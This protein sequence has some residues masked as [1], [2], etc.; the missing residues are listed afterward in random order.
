MSGNEMKDKIKSL[1][2]LRAIAVFLVIIT[3]ATGLYIPQHQA[4]LGAS[5]QYGVWLFFVLSAF[6]LT[7]R[8]FKTGFN[9][10]S[11]ASYFI[12]RTLR[13][14]P[15]FVLAVYVYHKFGFFDLNKFK[16]IVI[17]KE[18]FMHF[19]TIPIEYKFYFT[20]PFIAFLAIFS[21]SKFGLKSS[22][23]TLLIVAAVGQ[24]FYPYTDLS[25]GGK[26]MWML[27]I[28]L[29]GMIAACIHHAEAIK[30]G[31]M[32]ND[33]IISLCLL[34]FI[35]TMPFFMG[36]LFNMHDDAWIL[37][38]FIFL[39]PI[40]AIIVLIA[41]QNKGVISWALSSPV[42]SYIGKWSFSIYLWHFLILCM[43]IWYVGVSIPM[44]FL[45]MLASIIVGAISFY[46][47]ENPMEM[48]RHKIMSLISGRTSETE[49]VY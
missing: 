36:V 46:L 4:S 43:G 28:F 21:Q 13:I 41:S 49:R 25:L 16:D 2:G 31:N 8:F 48:L 10:K 45:S 35:I 15:V 11:L 19:W 42:L 40:L 9:I 12:G 17:F 30:L 27:P 22:V 6:L 18:P 3:H 39:S 24:F 34:V 32:K 26:V 5:S 23:L 37:N 33:I 29:S 1:D 38:K 47:I 14:I 20:L 7:S 44:Y